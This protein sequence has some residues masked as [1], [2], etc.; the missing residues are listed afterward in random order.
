M[1]IAPFLPILCLGA[2]VA[3][4]DI[5]LDPDQDGLLDDGEFLAGTDPDNPDSDGDGF[6]DGLEVSQYTDPLSDLD[7]PYTGGWNIGACRHDPIT[8][9]GDR[10][11]DVTRD[12]ALVDQYGDTLHLYDFCDRAVL[13]VSAALWCGN[14]QA[15]APELETWYEELAERG[16]LPITLIGED[17]GRNPS[18][19][20]DSAA[21]ADR[22]GLQHPVVTDSGWGVTYRYV[23]GTFDLPS[24]HLLGPGAEVIS[25]QDAV[26]RTELESH[27]PQ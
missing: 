1:R 26:T 9:T 10:P 23:E 19:P 8:A 4:V 17:T 11:G 13:L 18:E 25:V 3:A 16:F 5:P 24:M 2:C 14:C 7:H 15:E 12:F 20:E 27:L 22:Y 21:W 6:S